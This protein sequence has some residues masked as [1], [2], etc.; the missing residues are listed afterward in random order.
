M[1]SLSFLLPLAL[2]SFVA[3][4]TPGPNNV[5]LVSSVL[6]YGVRRTLPHMAGII[7]GIMLM[8]LVVGSGLGAVFAQ[9]PLLHR[10]LQGVC[11]LYLLYLAWRI[12]TAPVMTESCGSGKPFSFWQA[13]MFQWV[14]PKAWA[15]A[16]AVV[17]VYIPAAHFFL[18]LCLAMLVCGLVNLPAAL[19]WALFGMALRRL[20]GMALLLVLSLYPMLAI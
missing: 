11:A 17:A 3:A 15:F 4:V 5:M 6:N 1:T 12:A 19:I 18:S 16:L 10:L 13:A 8:L 7:L 9:W 2:F 20:I 14:N